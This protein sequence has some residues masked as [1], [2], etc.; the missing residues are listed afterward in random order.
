[1]SKNI[2]EVTDSNFEQEVLKSEKPVLIDFWAEWCGP[3]RA[4]APTVEALAEQQ[5]GNLRVGKM[6]VDFN[7][8][9]PSRYG[10][11]GIPTLIVFKGG[12]EVERIVGLV[13]KSTIENA[14]ARHTGAT[15]TV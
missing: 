7:Q 10:V 2:I 1:M 6:N 12:Q 3:C 11:R 13:N 4:I 15:A 5:A 8:N 14:V 9:V